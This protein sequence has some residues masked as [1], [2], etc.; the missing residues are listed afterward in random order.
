MVLDEI[1]V[2][3]VSDEEK[4]EAIEDLKQLKELLDSEIIAQEEFDDKKAKLLEKL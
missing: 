4:D 2:M 1:A 3:E